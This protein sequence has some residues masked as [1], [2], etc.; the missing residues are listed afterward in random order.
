ML[1]YL[2]NK[3]LRTENTDQMLTLHEIFEVYSYKIQNDI[4]KDHVLSQKLG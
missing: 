1:K 3:Y 4:K 2:L